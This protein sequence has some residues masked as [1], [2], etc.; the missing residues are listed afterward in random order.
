MS[1]ELAKVDETFRICF[2][3]KFS[4]FLVTSLRKLKLGACQEGLFH[5]ELG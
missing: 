2:F 1:V 3:P 4:C 5:L